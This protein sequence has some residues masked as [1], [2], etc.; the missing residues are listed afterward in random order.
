MALPATNLVQPIRNTPAADSE[1]CRATSENF[2]KLPNPNDEKAPIVP[3]PTE[4]P[5]TPQQRLAMEHLLAGRSFTKTAELLGITPRTLFEWRRNPAFIN[6]LSLMSREALEAVAMRSRNLLLIG[7][8]RLQRTMSF[9]EAMKVIN[10][11]RIWEL[12]NI[13]PGQ[14]FDAGPDQEPVPH[15]IE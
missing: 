15:E 1:S 8:D 6:Q 7:T 13:M 10:S 2:R 9:N 11:K 5:L 12:A 14:L 4:A 3:R